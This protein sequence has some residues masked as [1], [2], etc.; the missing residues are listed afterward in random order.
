MSVKE[1]LT[2][3]FKTQVI[4]DPEGKY[5]CN[6]SEM[7]VYHNIGLNTFFRRIKLGWSLADTLYTPVNEYKRRK[8]WKDHKGNVYSTFE[9]MCFAYGKTAGVVHYRLQHNYTLKDALEKPILKG[10]KRDFV[11]KYPDKVEELDS[12]T[13]YHST[14]EHRIKRNWDLYDADMI[15]NR[16]RKESPDGVVLHSGHEVYDHE[17]NL[18]HSI[19]AMCNFW[20]ISIHVYINRRKKGMSIEEILTTPVRKYLYTIEDHEGKIYRD[21]EDVCKTWNITRGM[22]TSRKRKGWSIKQILLTP[23]GQ[24]QPIED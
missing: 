7:C 22:Y 14:V 19:T 16:A 5:F 1:A 10:W 20:E 21:I 15:T 23:K 9:K 17:G 8:I 4:T 3:P 6:V 12:I 11:K 18:F 24:G 2:T 13:N